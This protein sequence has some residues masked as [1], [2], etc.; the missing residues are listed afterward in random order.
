[1]NRGHFQ[2]T[3][4][5]T[6]MI[7]GFV[8]WVLI[9]SLLPFIKQDIALGSTQLA[10]VTAIPVLLGSMLRIPVGYVTNRF[11]ARIVFVISFVFLI[12]PIFSLSRAHNF[13]DLALSGLLLGFAGALFSIGVTSMPKYYPR[14]RHGLV[15]GIY[16]I[17]NLGTAIST[18]AAPLL[19]VRYGWQNTVMM[20]IVLMGVF[21]V[22]NFI[23]G[24][25]HEPKVVTPLKE[26][27]MSTY[28]SPK[29]WALNFFYFIT[30]GS[31]VAFTVYLPNFLVL[32]F[33]LDKVTAGLYTAG[34]IV[35]ATLVRPIGGWLADRYNPFVVLMFVFC[36]MTLAG[37]LLSFSPTIHLYAVGCLGIGFCS[38]I[39]NGTVF[40][41][42]PLYFSKQGGIVNGIVSMFGGFGG[43]FPPLLLTLV[44]SLTGHYAIG[45]MAFSEFALGA[46][47]LTVWLF[48]QEKMFLSDRIIEHTVEGILITD[49]HGSIRRINPSFT[50]VTGYTAEEVLGRNPSFLK[51]GKQEPEFYRRMWDAIQTEGYWKGKVWN[52]R[53]NGELYQEWLTIS[54]VKSEAGDVLYYAGLFSELS[55]DRADEPMN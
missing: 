5:T 39:G 27:I 22:L 15:N 35:L 12:F 1:M 53:K 18:F 20:M 37:V 38:G 32:Q 29:L 47:I 52:K 8:V 42:V 6:S 2:L 10:W 25:R 13:I 31:F 55:Q 21:A 30:F 48:Y 24:D 23:F 17:G 14:E 43:F 46:L 54:A 7:A 45:F 50:R 51:S 41:L 9:S 28:R 36:G 34:F 44:H 49:I 26:Q 3:L 11:G 40:K 33:D 4:Q 16:A 19:A